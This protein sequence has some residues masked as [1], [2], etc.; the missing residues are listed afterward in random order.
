[1]ILI[2][3]HNNT[4]IR[5]KL[6]AVGLTCCHSQSPRWRPSLQTAPHHCRSPH[7]PVCAPEHALLPRTFSADTP[8]PGPCQLS[9]AKCLDRTPRCR[10]ASRSAAQKQWKETRCIFRIMY[11]VIQDTS[12]GKSVSKSPIVHQLNA[13]L[14][15]S[16]G[17]SIQNPGWCI[18]VT[19][20]IRIS[21]D[22]SA[23]HSRDRDK[24]RRV[25]VVVQ[26]ASQPAS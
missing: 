10:S 24:G 3:L 5:V 14:Y 11:C 26:P 25:P 1:M 16:N 9:Q 12:A 17:A 20:Y 19:A 15:G 7:K 6:L 21:Q 13:Q 4:A 18:H 22:G 8:G 23:S 2:I